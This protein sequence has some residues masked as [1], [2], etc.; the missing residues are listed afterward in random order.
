MAEKVK[1]SDKIA[2]LK[3]GM[4]WFYSDDF[5][6]EEASDRYKELSKLAKE[7]QQDLNELK[8]EIKVIE[9]DFSK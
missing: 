8:N 3:E 9:E 1:I 7:I 4:D 6:L 2:K 5:K